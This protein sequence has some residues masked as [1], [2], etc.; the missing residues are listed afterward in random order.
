[1]RFWILGAKCVLQYLILKT[2]GEVQSVGVAP[3]FHLEPCNMFSTKK[4]Y[5]NKQKK[6]INFGMVSLEYD[7]LIKLFKNNSRKTLDHKVTSAVRPNH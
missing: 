2:P 1:M 6:V 3:A 4:I 7:H 5:E